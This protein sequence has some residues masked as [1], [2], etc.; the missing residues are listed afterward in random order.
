MQAGRRRQYGSDDEDEHVEAD[1]DDEA[2]SSSSS[3]HGRLTDCLDFSQ[4]L[5]AP[6][7]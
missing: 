4:H 5:E 3:R 1:G 7:L 6:V 2:G